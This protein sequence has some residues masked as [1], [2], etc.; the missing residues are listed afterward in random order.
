VKRFFIP[1]KSTWISVVITELGLD[2]CHRDV[3]S[4]EDKGFRTP[5]ASYVYSFV[6]VIQGPM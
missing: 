4:L 6:V 2:K 3:L 5:S 1:K